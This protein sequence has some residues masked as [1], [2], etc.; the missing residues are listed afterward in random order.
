MT[1]TAPTPSGVRHPWRDRVFLWNVA[2]W[3]V[4]AVAAGRAL[5]LSLTQDFRRQILVSDQSSFLLS[6]LSIAYDHDLSYVPGDLARWRAVGWTT[7]PTGLFFQVFQDG[8]ANAKPYGYPLFIAPFIRVFGPGHGV[9]IANTVLLGVAVVA[10]LFL[11]HKRLSWATSAWVAT[12]LL[13]VSNVTLYALPIGVEPLY[14]ALV[15]VFFLATWNGVEEGAHRLAWSLTAVGCAAFLVAEKQPMLL[16]VL[17]AVVLLVV[18]QPGWGRRAA[19]LGAGLVVFA[20][21]VFPYWHYSNGTSITPYGGERYYSYGG[22]IWVGNGSDASRSTSD[23]VS[24]VHYVLEQAFQDL[25]RK[26]QAGGYYL[27]GQHTGL[28]VWLPFAVFVVIL[29]L[30]DLRRARAFGIV[31]LL[32]LAAYVAFYLVVFPSNTYGGS[33]VLGNR[34]FVQISPVIAAIVAGG[35]VKSRR[36]VAASMV[37]IVMVP[38]VLWPQFVVSPRDALVRMDRTSWIQSEVFMWESEVQGVKVF[39]FREIPRKQYPMRDRG[40]EP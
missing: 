21:S 22:L 16:L 33:Q 14:V 6:A 19:V 17:P 11:V 10:V 1:E 38:V 2:S 23:E 39:H 40:I 3:M 34:Y 8:T 9:A 31:A 37:S 27:L 35:A 26:W 20:V 7:D 28:L 12:A 4:F 30:I 15:S 29:T 36:L 5:F 32:G 18:R 24:G 25:P 13:L